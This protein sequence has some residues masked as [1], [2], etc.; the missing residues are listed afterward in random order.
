MRRDRDVKSYNQ[1]RIPISYYKGNQMN[2]DYVDDFE[3]AKTKY[4]KDGYT[5]LKLE[6]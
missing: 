2:F 1:F 6:K 5:V 3:K 4:E